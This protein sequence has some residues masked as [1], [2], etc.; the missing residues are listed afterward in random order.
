MKYNKLF[1][2]GKIGNVSLKNRIALPP[3]GT[4]LAKYSGEVGDELIRF[5]EERAKGGCGLV[6]TEITRIDDDY[7]WG[8]IRQMALTHDYQIGD[9]KRLTDAVHKYNSKLFVQLQHPGRVGHPD[10]NPTHMT[11]APSDVP[12]YRFS[13]KPKVLT[14]EEC[15]QLVEKFAAAAV[16]AQKG[17]ADGV[18]LHGAH[19]YLI[20]Q[21]LSPYTNKRT[22]K[23]GG[24]LENRCRF[25]DEI[26]AAIHK[27]C[28]KDFPVGIR[29][30]ADEFYG[31][32]GITPDMAVDIV[33]HF[34]ASGVSHIDMSCG[35][36]DSGL[37]IIP[38][39]PTEQGCRQALSAK[40]KA[41]VRIP[42]I[43]V[44]NI[45]TPE[46]AEMLLENDACDFVA[47][48]RAQ[49][50]D[51]QWG[52][53]ARAGDS[54]GI[55]KCIGCMRCF[56]SLGQGR[57]FHCS[58]NPCL[59]R[60][61]E[62]N[63][64]TLVRDGDGRRVVVVGGGPAGMQAAK[65]LAMR[66]FKVTL[67]EAGSR[68]GGMVNTADRNIHKEKLTWLIETMTHEMDALG[69]EVRLNERA[70][71][72]AVRSLDPVGIFV[73]TG[74]EHINPPVPGCDLPTAVLVQDFLH[75]KRE[76]GHKVA[77]IGSGATGVETASTLVE[78]GHD[79]TVIDMLPQIGSGIVPPLLSTYL[80]G[81]LKGLGVTMVPSYKLLGITES[82][83]MFEDLTRNVTV[84]MQFDN[85][86]LA[87][88]I[89]PNKSVVEAFAEQFPDI[90]VIGDAV[91]TATIL[92]AVNSANEQAWGFEP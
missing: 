43:S 42:V 66:N 69:I 50:A 19:G 76:V 47:L 71:P 53:K 31:D 25:A 4:M 26:I 6:I 37:Q 55:R 15:E 64:R 11:V 61:T 56:A 90:R 2:P 77:I 34:E 1:E 36:Q 92:E 81:R 27:A 28:G 79:V 48:G 24:S 51:P 46:V 75:G 33:R 23:Y 59:G 72:D 39:Y 18:E 14:T 68:L 45:K 49:L 74:G 8:M 40:I 70:T 7:G 88:G 86:I 16:R 73:C 54:L 44:S 41:A 84:E 20:N 5:Y 67:F 21:F 85:V 60:E 3:M 91:K 58:V 82:G 13:S 38:P 57:H 35:T 83:A 29:I 30:S 62:L 63:E 32:A 52:N 12:P 65:T 17:G 89:R 9:V 78:S 22:D 10:R 87:L 80:V